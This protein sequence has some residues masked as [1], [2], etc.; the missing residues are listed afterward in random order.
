MSQTPDDLVIRRIMAWWKLAVFIFL[1]TVGGMAVV[2]GL[3]LQSPVDTTRT[4]I[5]SLLCGV[6]LTAVI[7]GILRNGF[8]RSEL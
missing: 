6:P 7:E 1:G 5:G 3:L 8:G 4:A 2:D